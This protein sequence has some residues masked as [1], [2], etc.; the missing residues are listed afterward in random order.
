M[1]EIKLLNKI[2]PTGLAVLPAQ[3][4][5][6]G[7]DV[8]NPDGIMV[9]SASMHDMEFSPHLRAIARA[10]A[11][12]NNIPVERCSQQGIA[13][14]NT[15]GANANAVKEL[16]VMALLMSARKVFPAMEWVQSLHGR[17][18]EVPALVEKEKSRFSGPEIK[19]KKLGVIGMGL[20]GVEVINAAVDLGMEV[21]GYDPFLSVDT[22]M[23]IHVGARHA[24]TLKEI[25]EVCDFISLHLPV[26]SETKGM[27]NSQSIAMMK[28]GV[29]ILN[30]ARGELVDSEEMIAA[31]NERQVRCYIT[32]FPN[33]EILGHPGVIALPHLGASTP[34]SE[35]NCAEMAARQ[36][37]DF[38]ETGNVRNSVNLPDLQVPRS[39]RGRI[40]VIHR[41]IPTMLSQMTALVNANIKHLTNQ[42]KNGLAYT[43]MDLDE[44]VTTDMTQR[45]LDLEGVIAVRAFK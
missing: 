34:E 10:G 39:G 19:G 4:Y 1:H 5:R 12:V 6:C 9:R 35:D 3:S 29:R 13:V 42:S 30:F 25:Y 26:T 36:L 21:Y 7:E 17:G 37:K 2:S 44:R 14:F 38:L 32:D 31:L 33:D 45:I 24:N 43:V 23:K 27:I 11:G 16:T 41:N 15:P 18:S 8:E 28:P 22:A 20:I 40:T